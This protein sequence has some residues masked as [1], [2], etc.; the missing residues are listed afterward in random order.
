MMF[1]RLGTEPGEYLYVLENDVNGRWLSNRHWAVLYP[2]HLLGIKEMTAA[3]GVYY[4]GKN[5]KD[6]EFHNAADVSMK[7]VLP[8]ARDRGIELRR[9]VFHGHPLTVDFKEYGY[10]QLRKCYLMSACHDAV[11]EMD[12]PILLRKVYFDKIKRM[13]RHAEVWGTDQTSPV[14][15]GYPVNG[16]RQY[17]WVGVLMPMNYH[18]NCLEATIPEYKDKLRMKEGH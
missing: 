5:S 7:D 10:G 15:F 17:Q 18:V 16:N 9:Q 11:D 3:S 6:L 8:T 14:F 13:Y 1:S 12:P 2:T 4:R